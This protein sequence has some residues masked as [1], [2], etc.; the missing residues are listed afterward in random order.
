[1]DGFADTA[2]SFLNIQIGESQNQKA[3]RVHVMCAFFVVF[4]CLFIIVLRAIQ[5][6]NHLCLMAIEIRNIIAYYILSAEPAGIVAQ[7][8]VPESGFF[9]CLLLPKLLC[10]L[11]QVFV[12]FHA[13]SFL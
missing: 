10:K 11:F 12:L 13:V 6:Y 1:M 4:H 7:K 5:L 8:L 9:L 3:L 2:K